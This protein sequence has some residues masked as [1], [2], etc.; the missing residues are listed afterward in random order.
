MRRLIQFLTLLLPFAGLAQTLSPEHTWHDNNSDKG[1]WYTAQMGSTVGTF[2]GYLFA[3]NYRDDGNYNGGHTYMFRV[4]QKFDYTPMTPYKLGSSRSNKL[5]FGYENESSSFDPAPIRGKTFCFLFNQRLWYFQHAK[6]K[7]GE[8]ETDKNE[9]YECWAQMPID[10]MQSPF[11]F[12]WKS[13]PPPDLT[14]MGAFQYDSNLYFVSI[15]TNS[16]SSNYNKW[17][18]EEYSYNTSNNKFYGQRTTYITGLLNTQFGGVIRRLDYYGNEYFVVTT[19]VP[20]GGTGVYRLTPNKNAGYTQFTVTDFAPVVLPI[21]AAATIVEGS[22]KGNKTSDPYP[23][24]SDRFCVYSINYNTSSDGTHH[25]AYNEFKVAEDSLNPAF[26]TIANTGEVTIPSS[27]APNKG[28]GSLYQLVGSYQLKPTHFTNVFDTDSTSTYDGFIQYVWLFYP[29]KNQNFNGVLLQSDNWRLTG[30]PA[31]LSPDLIDTIAYPG[32][33][34][35]WSLIGICDNGPPCSVDWDKWYDPGNT[36]HPAGT[37]PTELE[38]TMTAGRESEVSNTYEDQ[39]SIGQDMD[40]KKHISKLE[41]SFSEEFKYSNTYKNTVAKSYEVKTTYTQTFGLSDESQELAVLLWAV[42]DI[43]RY[44]FSTFAWWDTGLNYPIPNS[45][46]YLFRMTNISIWPQYVPIESY[47]FKIHNPN[48]S[49]LANWSSLSR[50]TLQSSATNNGLKPICTPTWTSPGDGQSKTYEIT[51]QSTDSYEQTMEYEVNAGMS[52]GVPKVFD[53]GI[54]GGYKVS[55]TTETSVTDKFGTEIT[56]SLANLNSNKAGTKI[57]RLG[58]STYWFRNNNGVNWWYY[59]Y[60][61]D[62]RPW[63]IAYIVNTVSDGIRL[64]SP[65]NHAVTGEKE[66]FFSWE[67]EDQRLS[68]YELVISTSSP[69]DNTTVVFRQS[70]GDENS[71]LPSGF[72]PQAGKTYYWAVSGKNAGGDIINSDIFSFTARDD[73]QVRPGSGLRAVVY[74]NPGN[75]SDIHIVADAQVAGKIRIV[76]YDLDGMVKADREMACEKGVQADFNCAGLGLAPGIYFARISNGTEEV[77]RK[78]IIH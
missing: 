11:T 39:W 65:A 28:S 49:T 68:D 46:Q 67:D 66:L 63:Y 14:K 70:A 19:Y 47:P 32:I 53:V 50:D 1:R 35:L 40:I 51:G 17:A 21:T 58:I 55:Y 36:Y 3:F 26:V 78:I 34:K 27:T 23:Q 16:S 54:S 72:R 73:K 71:T 4:N 57:E 69:I 37:D 60:F 20:N 56:C 64:L 30:E 7:A 2:N 31:V 22:I 38:F 29:D 44:P 43:T 41:T 15:N 33:N 42:P 13:S 59:K 62:Q 48:D 25:I 24:F 12:Y 8:H 10:T 18:I 6:N 45:L 74:P 76:I 61:G 75:S 52:I 77:A 5:I 9:S